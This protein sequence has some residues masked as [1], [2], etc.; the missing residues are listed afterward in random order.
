MQTFQGK[1][2]HGL[3]KMIALF[4]MQGIDLEGFNLDLAHPVTGWQN[5]QR[6]WRWRESNL[7]SKIRKLLIN[8]ILAKMGILNV[9]T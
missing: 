3:A 9:H 7:Q 2:C 8:N 6:W 5:E 4:Y 1:S